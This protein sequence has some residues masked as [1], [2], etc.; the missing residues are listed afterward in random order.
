MLL[1]VKRV[2][3]GG[4]AGNQVGASNVNR[5]LN[6]VLVNQTKS[7]DM[8]LGQERVV[9]EQAVVIG[10]GYGGPVSVAS[11]MLASTILHKKCQDRAHIKI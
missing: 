8:T 3:G 9:D 5:R 2:C 1:L 10:G 6:A 7:T 11:L 4:H